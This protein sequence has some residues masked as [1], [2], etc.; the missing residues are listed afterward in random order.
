MGLR[1]MGVLKDCDVLLKSDR[2]FRM[3][4]AISCCREWPFSK[5]WP[6]WNLDPNNANRSGARR[7]RPCLLLLCLSFWGSTEAC[8]AILPGPR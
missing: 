5:A 1:S 8:C 7:P 3:Q 2:Q 6:A 4:P